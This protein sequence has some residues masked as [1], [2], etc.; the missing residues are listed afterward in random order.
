MFAPAD[1]ERVIELRNQANPTRLVSVAQLTEEDARRSTGQDLWARFVAERGQDVPGF[2]EAGHIPGA[3]PRR[4]RVFVT[5][6][7]G[8]REEGLGSALLAAAENWA[9]SR[10]AQGYLTAYVSGDDDDSLAWAEHRGYGLDLER[11]EAVLDLGTWNAGGFAGHLDSV[12]TAF[13]PGFEMVIAEEPL[14]EGLL[15][16]AYEV[17]LSASRDEPSYEGEAPSWDEWR[18]EFGQPASPKLMAIAL[19]EGR[20][21][22]TSQVTLPVEPD[23]KAGAHT[24][25]TGVLRDY[26]GRGLALA[27]KLLTIEAVRARGIST[28]T[29]TNDSANRPMLSLNRKL[30]YRIV[31]GPRRLKKALRT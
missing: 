16:G 27:L 11:S 29:A 22:G 31:P 17:E 23:V 2:G 15:R 26:R 9:L 30:G 12:R 28:M 21:V 13:G 6:A 19:A 5:V 24:N 10:G 1:Y 7:H 18:R 14:S 20:V 25:F 4:F 8:S 3:P